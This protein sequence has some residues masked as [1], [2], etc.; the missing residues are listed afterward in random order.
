LGNGAL[1]A[2]HLH[3]APAGQNGPVLQDIIVDAGGNVEGN[4]GFEVSV[5]MAEVADDAAFIAAADAGNLYFN[6]HTSDFPGGEIRGQ[7]DT[8]VSDETVDGLRQLAKMVLFFRILLSMLVEQQQTLVFC[9]KLTLSPRMLKL[10][11]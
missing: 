5:D 3:N 2:I 9:Q 4:S 8:V 10:I 11:N 6:V 7:L 1:S